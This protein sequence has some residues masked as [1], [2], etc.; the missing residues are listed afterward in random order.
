VTAGMLSHLLQHDVEH[1]RA[2]APW[3][4]F[5]PWQ[6][7]RTERLAREQSLTAGMLSP[8]LQHDIDQERVFAPWP[9]FGLWQKAR[10]ERLARDR[11]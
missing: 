8:L 9:G 1:E 4:A 7:A 5:G 6:N 10:P 3:P 11:A 2:V